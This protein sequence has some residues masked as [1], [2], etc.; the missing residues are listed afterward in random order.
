MVKGFYEGDKQ[1]TLDLLEDLDQAPGV[2]MNPACGRCG[3][4][5]G[6]KAPPPSAEGSGNKG[7]L[8]IVDSPSWK[9]RHIL[10][11]MLEDVG[12]EMSDDV[13]IMPAIACAPPPKQ[14]VTPNKVNCCRPLAWSFIDKVK[15]KI[16]IPMGA[17]AI[18]MLFAHRL[19]LR[20]GK[21]GQFN[22]YKWRG[23]CIP[24]QELQAWVC[25]TMHPDEATNDKA[26]ARAQKTLEDDL[27]RAVGYLE[28]PVPNH[29]VEVKVLTD[30][31]QVKHF[32]QGL[33]HDPPRIM[34]FDTETT[35]LK[36][37]REGH[38]IK[39]IGLSRLHNT[40]VGFPVTEVIEGL[41]RDLFS[42]P[43]ISF[44]AHNMK[45]DGAW[46][47]EKLGVP[48]A[49]WGWDSYLA[50]HI[51][52][53]RDGITGLKFQTAVQFGIFNYDGDCAKFLKA[54]DEEDEAHGANGIN[55]IDEA[56]LEALL[57]YVAMDAVYT[58]RLS[59]IQKRQ[60]G[61]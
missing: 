2:P 36:P 48:V 30:E 54:T 32:L 5:K 24:D 57:K 3:Y 60:F 8:I 51:L 41:L 16:I 13:W 42:H 7:V 49:K 33:L 25:P 38:K 10:D 1:G 31:T 59:M 53:N 52:D 43:D 6:E 61:G 23:W 45:F 56:P 40:A 20:A 12:V 55:R 9:G 11:A 37:H 58:M 17:A 21:D 18:T 44:V 35:G 19:S 50:A 14:D 46:V 39:C 22:S 15:P 29:S 34:A 28:R 4:L 47:H 26:L 27:L